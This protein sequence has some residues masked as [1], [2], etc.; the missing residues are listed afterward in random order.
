[1]HFASTSETFGREPSTLDLNGVATV[2]KAYVL[3]LLGYDWGDQRPT[4]VLYHD[5]LT[6]LRSAVVVDLSAREGFPQQDDSSC[7]I[8]TPEDHH[9]IRF[10][11]ANDLISR[12]H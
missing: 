4:A 2:N 7:M 8:Y 11:R 6:V 1:M 10:P 5:A 12:I 3:S 9:S